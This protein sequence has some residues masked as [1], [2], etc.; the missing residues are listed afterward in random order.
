VTILHDLLIESFNLRRTFNPA[1]INIYMRLK[2]PSE[3]F[4]VFTVTNEN[5]KGIMFVTW[6]SRAV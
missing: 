2:T 3:S 1:V 6:L 4:L 5:R